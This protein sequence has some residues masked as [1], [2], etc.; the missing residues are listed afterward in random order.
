M[1]TEERV[2]YWGDKVVQFVNS[3]EAEAD[4]DDDAQFFLQL[5]MRMHSDNGRIHGPIILL[6]INSGV[7]L[8]TEAIVTMSRELGKYATRV[9]ELQNLVEVEYTEGVKVRAPCLKLVTVSEEK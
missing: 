6:S 8:R 7:E 2:K 3:L 1:M 5:T 9:R 4:E